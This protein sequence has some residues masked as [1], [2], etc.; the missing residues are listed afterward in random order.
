[1]TF[2]TCVGPHTK[3]Q[4]ETIENG[5]NRYFNDLREQSLHP[6]V[7][8]PMEYTSNKRWRPAKDKYTQKL[9]LI[10]DNL[11]LFAR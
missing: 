1:M 8:D 5:I 9:D 6:K 2:P 11:A 4:Q 3:R 7:L 10:I